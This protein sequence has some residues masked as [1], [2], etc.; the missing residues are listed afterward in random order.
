MGGRAPAA[1]RAQVRWADMRF[2]RQLHDVRVP[3]PAGDGQQAS[4]LLL[5]CAAYDFVKADY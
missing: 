5:A 4:A 1:D 3:L 2:E